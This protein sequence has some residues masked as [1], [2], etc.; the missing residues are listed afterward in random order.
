MRG[1]MGQRRDGGREG[2]R[3][4]T[5][6]TYHAIAYHA[7]G[8][9]IQDTRG[10]QVK[11]VFNPVYVNSVACIRPPGDTSHHVVFLGENVNCRRRKGGTRRR[12]GRGVSH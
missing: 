7:G 3:G 5:K 11:F 2:R 6:G 1:S 10:H 9:G 12:E 4:K 8:L